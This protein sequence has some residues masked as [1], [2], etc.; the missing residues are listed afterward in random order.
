M[1]VVGIHNTGINSSA[2]IAIDGSLK[3]GYLEER[4][5]RRK[6]DKAFPHK[7][8]E[9]ILDLSNITHEDVDVFAISWNPAINIGDRYRA[10]FSDW[11]AY[12]GHRFS[13]NA[14][15]ILPLLENKNFSTTEQIFGLEDQSPYRISYVSHHKAHAAAAFYASGFEDA[16]V[17]TCDAYGEKASA[18]WFNADKS[19][20]TP[21]GQVAFP[22][23]IGM[24]Y[25]TI[26]EYLGFRPYLDEWKVMGASAYGNPK[27]YLED[28]RKLF[29]CMEGVNFELNLEY[30]QFYNY[31]SKTTYSEKLID[32]FGPY[33]SYVLSME[34][35]HFDIAA[36]A[37][38]VTEEYFIGALKDLK[39]R[40]NSKN[41]CLSGGVVMN[42]VVN[43]VIA[44]S[45]IFDDIYIPFAPDDSGNSIGAALLSSVENGETIEAESAA[46]PFL[47]KSYSEDDILKQFSLCKLEPEKLDNIYE[48]TSDLLIDGKIVGWFQGKMEF[49]QRAL[50]S[51]S[52][53]ADPRN[54][55]MKDRIN[56]AVKFRESFRPFAP[57]VLENFVEQWFETSHTIS[58]PYME[59]VINIK[60]ELA[61]K[62]PA[63]VHEDGSCRLQ[64]V[65]EKLT[66][67]FYEL[68][69][70]FHKKTEVPILLNTSFNI[71]HEPIVESPAD[72]IR[73]F[74]S[75]GL[76]A[77]VIGRYL[78]KK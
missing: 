24:F 10:G 16:I 61:N 13:S 44:D 55:D 5:S 33:R 9:R 28:M 38:K 12:P 17:F 37:Q 25:S 15:H 21:V 23:S 7:A 53:L 57:A 29:K 76:D 43:G 69:N 26:T 48:A 71:N 68:I 1:I 72:A 54:N 63:V 18:C 70:S 22:H 3:F 58:S 30:F 67:E 42:S 31:D 62:V 73:T 20:I 34:Q 36:A 4:I 27:T 78:L 65:T 8:L 49:G 19:S 6:Y 50:G 47:G 77:L 56:S 60:K 40:T 46:T 74:F 66:P 64:T 59:K 11:P 35:R 52:I 39:E 14:N 75:S 45:G 41:I 2:A 51:R 32:L